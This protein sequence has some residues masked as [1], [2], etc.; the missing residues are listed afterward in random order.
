MCLCLPKIIT[1]FP[2]IKSSENTLIKI[3][4]LKAD[5]IIILVV[6]KK[7][8]VFI[9][10]P[11]L[12]TSSKGYSKQDFFKDLSAGVIVGIIAIPLSIALGVA[13]GVSIEMGLTT[14][15]VAGF[16]V[17]LLGGSRVQIGGPTG[18]FVVIVYGIVAQHGIEGL[19]LATIMAG[20]I[21]ILLGVLKL[22]TFIQFIPYPITTGFTTGIAFTI[23]ST[24]LK[25]FLGLTMAKV[26]SETV[27]KY[28]A[29]FNALGSINWTSLIIGIVAILIIVY[30]PKINQKIPGSLIAI[31]FTTVIV[32]VFHLD[33]NTIGS[34]FGTVGS[35]IPHFQIPVFNLNM[36]QS[37]IQP[38]I[39]IALL[40]SIESLLSAVVADGM[41]GDKHDS[42]MELMAQGFANVASGFLGGI[43]ATGAIARTAANIK[44]GGRTP[45]AGIIHALT[46]L[47]AMVIF[48]PL[49]KLIPMTTLAAILIVVAY[50]M[51]EVHRFVGLFKSTKSDIA[52][53]LITFILTVFMDLV[54]A[55]E[56]GMVLAALLFMKRM[57]DTTEVG[58]IDK[59]LHERYSES[60][61]IRKTLMDKDILFYQIK[62]PF[63]FGA[64]SKFIDTIDEIKIR[65]K[66]LVLKMKD[67]PVMDATGFNALRTIQKRCET[68]S[69][70]LVLTNVQ[71][72]P[73]DLMKKNGF[74]EKVG[75]KNIFMNIDLA[76]KELTS[77]AS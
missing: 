66:T 52:V 36:V 57:A 4:T 48:M 42:N 33:I 8:G 64:A 20:L 3:F 15:I 29:Y 32:A 30:W 12:F 70:R 54:V 61:H 14:A 47:M 56:V 49:V 9:L 18:A 17:S 65:P 21:M 1:L 53:L 69:I 5:R 55:I 44:N 10:R 28:I 46:V 27:P 74:V 40:A 59:M 45:I 26:P 43:P 24:Q 73:Y 11:K 23:F 22:G 77:K 38:A 51:S 7:K 2:K 16:F 67:V 72:Q 60:E 63:F 68:Y 41:I 31:I 76:L 58:S 35:P 19:V 34:Q 62:G 13:S 6:I 39:T 37:L 71:R 25:D 75:G 50:N